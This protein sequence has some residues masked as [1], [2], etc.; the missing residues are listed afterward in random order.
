MGGRG[1]AMAVAVVAAALSLG[2]LFPTD[3]D[4]YLK[5]TRGLDIFGKAYREISFRYVEAIDPEELMKY[6]IEQMLESL[7]PYTVFIDDTRSDELDFLT[8]GRYG[9]IGVTVGMRDSVIVIASVLEGYAADRAGVHVDDQILAVDTVDVRNMHLDAVRGLVR[10][11]PGT[12]LRL[13]VQREG[14]PAPIDFQ[15]LRE[16]ILLK[17]VT[18]ARLLDSSIGY[19]KLEHFTR[20]AGEEVRNA[21]RSL[22]EQGATRIVLDL[23]DNPGGLLD[24]AVSVV[25]QFVPRGN[26]IVSTHG[27][28][29]DADHEYDS[30][31]EPV[32]PDLPLVVLV[33]RESASASEIVAGAIQDLDRGL[34][35]GRRT[36]G[37]GLVQT[38]TP[39][40]YN[41]SLKLTTAKY[42]TP[43]GRCIQEIDY[44]HRRGD[45]FPAFPDSAKKMFYTRKKRPVLEEGGIT[46]DSTVIQPVT[47]DLVLALERKNIIREFFDRNADTTAVLALSPA[48]LTERFVHFLSEIHARYSGRLTG[49]LDSAIAEVRGLGLGKDIENELANV[50]AHVGTEWTSEIQPFRQQLTDRLVVAREQR[51]HG[52]AAGIAAGL[53]TDPVFHAA[54]KLL[55]SPA[56]MDI[57]LGAK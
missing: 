5:I 16:E 48:Q 53:R 41:T 9:G 27:R 54:E 47:S 44:A 15:M 30:E 17:N 57:K 23:R 18:C 31:Q 51:V 13:R 38:V 14:T 50:R 8:N 37:K 26:R 34:I 33:D 4:T 32:A 6:G 25:E 36:F 46:P 55:A 43:S 11:L 19:V 24:Q 40:P 42:Y 49:E 28:G 10:G 2:F 39:L 45:I 22:R 7:D 20:G 21:L 35:V 56:L 29:P 3:N 12:P 52:V 1:R